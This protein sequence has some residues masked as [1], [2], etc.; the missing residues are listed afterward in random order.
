MATKK[1]PSVVGASLL[2]QHIGAC[3]LAV[4][5]ALSVHKKVTIVG[6]EGDLRSNINN[7][8]SAQAKLG[9][10]C[11]FTASAFTSVSQ[12]CWLKCL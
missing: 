9:R 10:W 12:S 4:V 8:E 1:D 2:I 6:K 3:K 11:Q 7:P 5:D